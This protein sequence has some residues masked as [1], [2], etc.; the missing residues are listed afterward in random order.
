MEENKVNLFELLSDIELLQMK[1]ENKL[2]EQGE[3]INEKRTS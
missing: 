1:I 2:K 3:K